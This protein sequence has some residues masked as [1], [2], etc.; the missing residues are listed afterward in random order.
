MVGLDARDGSDDD[1]RDF[2]RAWRSEQLAELAGQL[3]RVLVAANLAP[4]A[5]LVSAGCGDFLAQSLAQTLGRR[6][7][8]YGSQIASTAPSAPPGTAAW[9]QVCAPSVAVAALFEQAQR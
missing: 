3:E 5:P 7:L 4:D 1:W 8:G 6:C 2:A 9:A